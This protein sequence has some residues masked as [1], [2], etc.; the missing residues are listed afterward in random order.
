MTYKVPDWLEKKITYLKKKK[1]KTRKELWMR[2]YR[3][4]QTNPR[5][6]A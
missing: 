6:A 5:P 2:R 3:R 1:Q 4:N